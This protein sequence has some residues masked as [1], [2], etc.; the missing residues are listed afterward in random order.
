MNHQQK[1]RI[2][3]KLWGWICLSINCIIMAIFLTHKFDDLRRAAIGLSVVI[4]C[5]GIMKTIVDKN[6][7]DL[8]GASVA[9]EYI[10]VFILTFLSAF[11]VLEY[12][13]SISLLITLVLSSVAE[14]LV[15]LLITYWY[16]IRRFF[17]QAS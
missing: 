17:S 2:L 7:N 13:P 3:Q 12:L 4:I 16:V 8:S 1:K 6:K 9:I 14:L 5:Y 11:K 15:F 10:C